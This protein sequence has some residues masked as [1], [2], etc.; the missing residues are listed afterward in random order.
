LGAALLVVALSAFWF[1]PSSIRIVEH[2]VMLGSSISQRPLR[3]AIIADLHAG[4]PFIDETKIDR[5]V[6]LTNAAKPDLVL[7]T[8]DFVIQ[9]VIGG[10]H[11]PIETTAQKLRALKAPLGVYSVLGNHDRWEDAEHIASALEAAGIPVLENSAAALKRDNELLYLVGLSDAYTTLPDVAAAFLNVPS[12]A[13]AVCF[14]H[15]PDVFPELP[16]ACALTIAAHTHGGQVWLPFVGRPIV[17]SRFGQ[18]Y[19]AGLVEENGKSLF[20]ST[21]IGTSIIPV[22]LGVPPEIAILRVK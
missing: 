9:G 16:A 10:A 15:S 13:K 2:D 18:R 5:V 20:V 3:I 21:G 11:I 14:T 19:A 7:L 4:A 22:R 17:P 1:E 12:D 8:G 6:A